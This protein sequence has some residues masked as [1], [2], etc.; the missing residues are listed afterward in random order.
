[1]GVW[2]AVIVNEA[3]NAGRCSKFY[4]L[5]EQLR[6]YTQAYYLLTATPIQLHARELYDLIQLLDLAGGWDNRDTSWRFSKPE[7]G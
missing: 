7:M 2:D 5:L 1:M 6:D 3:H 4:A